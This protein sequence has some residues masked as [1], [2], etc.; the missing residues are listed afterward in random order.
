MLNELLNEYAMLKNLNIAKDFSKPKEIKLQECQVFLNKITPDNFNK[1]NNLNYRD[2][3]VNKLYMFPE[4]DINFII[5]VPRIFDVKNKLIKM[6]KDSIFTLGKFI[7]NENLWSSDETKNFFK[8]YLSI[9]DEEYTKSSFLNLFFMLIDEIKAD[10]SGR[11]FVFLDKKYGEPLV[12]KFIKNYCNNEFR[13][14]YK[15]GFNIIIESL[16]LQR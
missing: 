16:D 2:V 11:A 10:I 7:A 9:N 14:F 8:N 1:L 4:T 15:L 6:E 12:K 5:R 3:L 13:A